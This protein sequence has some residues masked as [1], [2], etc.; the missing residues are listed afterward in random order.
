M[1]GYYNYTVILTYLGMLSGFTGITFAMKGNVYAAL[2]CL[3]I[4]GSPRRS[5][6]PAQKSASASRSIL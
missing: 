4:A 2:I 3:M 5:S 6:E 1:L